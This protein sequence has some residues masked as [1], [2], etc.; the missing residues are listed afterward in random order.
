MIKSMTGFGQA[1]SQTGK[2]QLT[3]EMKSVN[4]RFLELAVRMPRELISL[5][6]QV[7]RKIGAYI[8]RGK[9]DVFI[10]VERPDG[11]D[12]KV[13]VN[14]S[15]AGEYYNAYQALRERFPFQDEAVSPIEFLSLPEIVQ[16]KEPQ[17]DI[18]KY[19][20]D[21]LDSVELACQQLIHMRKSEGKNLHEDIAKRIESID[22]IID[23]IRLRTPAV[24][25]QYQ[26]RLAY[27]MKE[28]LSGHWE[29]DEGRILTE[30]AI[31]AEKVNIDEELIRLA[32]H[33]QQ[34]MAILQEQEPVG[35]K[36]DFLVQEMNRETNTIG[37]KAND[38]EI[39]KRVVDLKAE[40]E[41][42][43]EQVQNIE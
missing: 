2:I 40:L 3:V 28:M 11:Q 27:R 19:A 7:K 12:Q 36:L 24:V 41:K 13:V 33:C 10:N 21:I 35:R 5:E 32:S 4:H 14:W 43:K 8:R 42:I 18:Q 23:E 1:S 25:Q 29:G 22:H 26:E 39:S 6:E 37:S 17:E 20:K 30:V 15:L 9:V 38:L 31:F 34:F 16:L